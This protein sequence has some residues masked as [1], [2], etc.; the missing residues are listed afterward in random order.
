MT[1]ENPT[2]PLAD[3]G[4]YLSDDRALPLA[5]AVPEDGPE[6]PPQPAGPEWVCPVCPDVGADRPGDCPVCGLAF[7]PASLSV[8][9]D[10]ADPERQ[11]MTRRL[12]LAVALTV[13][14]VGLTAADLFAD[15]APVTAT[16]GEKAF[17]ALQAV[18][19]T[20][21]VFV[22][23]WPFLVR[24]WRSIRTL[25]PNMFTLVGLGVG[26]AYT[27]SLV[28]LVYLWSGTRPL[29]ATVGDP[30]KLRP[31]VAG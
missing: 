27:Y 5:G 9:P 7:E 2:S 6:P 22:S 15:D 14:L 11:S 3:L 28:A 24:A 12:W 21:V 31:I 16:L 10:A 26:A 29:P 4:Q 20:P 18:L 30:D 8:D 19:C 1:P 25:R 23:G 13:P 17:L